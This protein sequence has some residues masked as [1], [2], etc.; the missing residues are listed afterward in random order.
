MASRAVLRH[1]LMIDRR[2]RVAGHPQKNELFSVGWARNSQL[3]MSVKF[4][5]SRQPTTNTKWS[6]TKCEIVRKWSRATWLHRPW[7]WCRRRTRWWSRLILLCN[8]T[9]TSHRNSRMTRTTRLAKSTN[10]VARYRVLTRSRRNHSNASDTTQTIM[11][12]SKD[13]W[14]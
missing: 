6:K 8:T 2:F 9:S 13:R 5:S 7:W 10:R 4:S 11:L 12:M 3:L 14:C 1:R